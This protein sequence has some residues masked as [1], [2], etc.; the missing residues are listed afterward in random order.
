MGFV[1]CT[2]SLRDSRPGLM[3]DILSSFS[4][5]LDVLHMFPF[6]VWELTVHSTLYTFFL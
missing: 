6:L 1:G 2:E 4:I 3:L 5:E